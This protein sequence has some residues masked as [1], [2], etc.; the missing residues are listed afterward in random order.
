MNW[1]ILSWNVNGLRASLRKG[2]L[3]WVHTNSPDILALQ[4]TKANLDQLPHELLHQS[5]YQFFLHAAERP[6]YSG[7]AILSKKQPKTVIKEIDIPKFDCEGR[8][9]GVEYP[10]FL[11][12]NV[13]FP[14]G[15]MNAN[16]LNYKLE[17]YAAFHSY[18]NIQRQKGHNL[19]VCGDYN[20]AHKEID[21]ARPKPN[22]K[23]SGFLPIERK[24]MDDLIT[25]GYVDTFREFNHE[26][27]QYSWWDVRTGARKRNIGWR[28]DYFFVNKEFRPRVTDA[29]ILSDVQGSDHCPVGIT[30]KI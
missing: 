1:Q 15:K 6:G 22:S 12:F 10:N 21:L 19:I 24:W 18:L 3:D 25:D 7:V 9:I 8:I 4:E 14:N 16:R 23:R 2:F 5:D 26:P 30:I 17:F 28:I 29:F 27:N 11:L 13:Y 20:T